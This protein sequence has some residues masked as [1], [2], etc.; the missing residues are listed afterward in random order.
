MGK[1]TAKLVLAYWTGIITDQPSIN[2]WIGKKFHFCKYIFGIFI[3]KAKFGQ[4]IYV[5]IC[6]A[7]GVIQV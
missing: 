2:M 1:H 4:R 6:S 3:Q 5:F 7:G